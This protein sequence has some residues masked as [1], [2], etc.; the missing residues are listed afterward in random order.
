MV[1]VRQGGSQRRTAVF[2]LVVAAVVASGTYLTWRLYR[3]ESAHVGQQRAITDL[4][5]T[6]EC[7]TGE[8]FE[9]PGAYGPRACDDGTHS[10]DIVLRCTCPQHG[11]F[12]CYV[13]YRRDAMGLSR[14]SEIRFEKG[15]WQPVED[16]IRCP[17][18]KR[19]AQMADDI[20]RTGKTGTG[21]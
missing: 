3:R 19:P 18:C 5:V 14:L 17:I 8:R 1:K 21:R 16:S 6:W 9:A 20:F 7:D 2:S 13:R 10:A 4:T 12:E 11:A 15:E